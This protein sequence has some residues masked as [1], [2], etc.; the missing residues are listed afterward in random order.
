[1]AMLMSRI[2]TISLAFVVATVN[3]AAVAGTNAAV[4]AAAKCPQATSANAGVLV[5]DTAV[6]RELKAE[7]KEAATAAEAQYKDRYKELKDAHD[8]FMSQLNISL[9]ILAALVTI[10]G[11]V[12]PFV[13]TIVEHNK[14][15]AMLRWARDRIGREIV[16]ARDSKKRAIQIIRKD[17]VEALHMCLTQA[18]LY[19][20]HT[21]KDEESKND[22]AMALM[23]IVLC[24]YKTIDVAVRTGDETIVRKQI[25]GFKK[26]ADRW[27]SND[28]LFPMKIQIW[29]IAVGLMKNAEP[30]E[31]KMSDLTRIL[32]DG[33]EAYKWFKDFFNKCFPG[34]VT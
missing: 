21:S 9:A 13:M 28:D 19:Y 3:L 12:L 4:M 15:R 27:S 24:F 26:F 5:S 18:M 8:R 30:M 6:S 23:S 1:M 31:C 11:A 2:R 16:E 25:Q 14:A 34:R 10:F 17:S 7:V 33:S 32:G 20:N 29:E 22:A